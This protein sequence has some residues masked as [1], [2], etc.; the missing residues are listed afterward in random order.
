M[1]E[2]EKIM[3]YAGGE[4][5]LVHN[6]MVFDRLLA[7]IQRGN[8]VPFIGAG[9]SVPIY[10][11]WPEVLR[12]ISGMLDEGKK[13]EFSSI[14]DKKDDPDSYTKAADYLAEKLGGDYIVETLIRISNENKLNSPA[15][16]D[17]TAQI[18]PFLFR[19]TP[20]I[21]TNY[22]RLLEHIYRDHGKRFERVIEP[23]TKDVRKAIQANYHF[24]TK[25]HGDI[26]TDTAT[27]DIIFTGESYEIAYKED[28]ELVASLSDFY[29]GKTML[30]LGSSLK[31][32]RTLDVLKKIS[33]SEK[34]QHYVILPSSKEDIL[35]NIHFF[36]TKGIDVIFY[37]KDA[38]LGHGAVRVILEELL[39][40]IDPDSYHMYML[41]KETKPDADADPFVYTTMASGFFGREKEMKALRE[42]VDSTHD[43]RWWGIIGDGGQGKSRLSLELENELKKENWQVIRLERCQYNSLQSINKE[44]EKAEKNFIIAD[45]GMCYAEMLGEWMRSL[46]N[47]KYGKVRVLILERKNTNDKLDQIIIQQGNGL[48]E[49]CWDAMM[50]LQS[51]GED[52]LIKVMQAYA[53]YRGK[54]LSEDQ[55]DV[56]LKTLKQIDEGLERPLFAL[57]LTDALCDGKDPKNWDRKR[58]LEE[59][60]IRE[61]RIIKQNMINASDDV[62]RNNADSVLNKAINPLRLIATFSMDIALDSL[63]K[64]YADKWD[65]FSNRFPS[66]HHESDE[67]KSLLSKI[68]ILKNDM[69]EALRPD[70]LGEFFVLSHIDEIMPQLFCNNWIEDIE[71]DGFIGRLVYD[72][73]DEIKNYPFLIRTI[74][75]VEPDSIGSAYGLSNILFYLSATKLRESKELTNKTMI[76]CDKYKDNQLI[77]YYC[78]MIFV[79][80]SYGRST[81]EAEKMIARIRRL[82]EQHTTN[83]RFVEIWAYSLYNLSCDQSCEEAKKT[84]ATIQQLTEQYPINEDIAEMLARSLYNLSCDQSCTEVEKTIARIQRLVEMH[85]TN[86]TIAEK[87]AQSLVNLCRD[88]SPQEI[89]RIVTR[90][91]QL[92]EQ[93]S[94]NEGIAEALTKGLFILSINQIP[95]ELEKT[96]KHI[97]QQAERYPANEVIAVGLAKSLLHLSYDQSP[98]EAEKTIERI[99][100]LLD[101]HPINEGIAEALANGLL[102][103]S[104]DQSPEIA[105][106]TIERIQWLSDQHPAS[107]GIAAVL[108]NG[109]IVLSLDQSP[110]KVEKTIERIYRLLD[111]YPANEDY[112]EVLTRGLFELSLNQ[113]P[114]DAEKTIARIQQ[115]ADQYPANETIAEEL[116]RSLFK[117]CSNLP[118]ER[119]EKTIVRI[120]QLAEQHPTNEDIALRLA[121][122][123]FNLSC[124]QSPDE[125]E[126]TIKRIQQLAEQHSTNEDITVELATSLLN[127]TCGQSHEKAEK[128]TARIQKLVERYPINEKLAV[129]LAKSL[130]N[131]SCDQS[132][133]E[134]E[135]TI[136]RIRKLMD[137]YAGNEDIAFVLAKG[138]ANL[139]C[140][141][142]PDEAKNTMARIRQ[143]AEQHTGNEEISMVL[144]EGLINL[145][146]K[147]LPNG[148]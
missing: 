128:I 136:A 61:D 10:P 25:L 142:S 139:S 82:A 130:F 120:Q 54:T 9:M 53:H 73:S 132:P 85:P 101:Q 38:P 112:A 105:E 65:C 50:E 4:G 102:K 95:A 59:V 22:D 8:V 129:I 18:L 84:I 115:L 43:F 87:L 143:L 71:K 137:Q 103:L 134:A 83:E 56:L 86:A 145:S 17:L 19:E 35:N 55:E 15:Y 64:N 118:Y 76:L 126:N 147:Q 109:L 113:S 133:D 107:E 42:F 27:D 93:H 75:E 34:V 16:K 47:W 74:L 122:S 135:N 127:M 2:F 29:R 81:E 67:L 111:Q 41:S 138:W 39:R 30:F 62:S 37:D 92:A 48:R 89:E 21:T 123:L 79:N 124:D 36:K 106:R 49:N 146:G 100:W 80:L 99:Q 78:S 33:S 125:A 108:T 57:F 70:L 12:M 97:Q 32:D 23:V 104:L 63:A 96:I 52:A 140:K 6:Q 28:G 5:E 91:R 144:E 14:L 116:T 60:L 121:R 114:E 148:G 98:Q 1:T 110:E 88:Q 51:I 131:L 46:I 117:L 40:G 26:G 7:A 119:L 58:V 3:K 141:Q 77:A 68:G 13:A 31:Y 66:C 44:L 69:I 94:N 20:V 72:Y 24:L 45:Y 90:I 11:Q